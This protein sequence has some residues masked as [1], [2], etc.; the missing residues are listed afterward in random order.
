MAEGIQ[1]GNWPPSAAEMA[2]TFHLILFSKIQAPGISDPGCTMEHHQPAASLMFNAR[3]PKKED[4]APH[5]ASQQCVT[6]G[7]S[8][9]KHLLSCHSSADGH[10]PPVQE[11]YCRPTPGHLDSWSRDP[12]WSMA[13]C[14]TDRGRHRVCDDLDEGSL[15]HG[16]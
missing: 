3:S 8:T 11:H 15:V 6:S 5:G 4:R 1:V 9:K 12:T 16:K 10:S 13:L 14:Q 7:S 2:P